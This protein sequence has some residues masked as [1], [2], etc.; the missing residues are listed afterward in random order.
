VPGFSTSGT[1][2]HLLWRWGIGGTPFPVDLS[3]RWDPG[4]APFNFLLGP[5]VQIETDKL[6]AAGTATDGV[7]LN[8]VEDGAL[9]RGRR[10][11]RARS[12]THCAS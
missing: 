7:T 2:R 12:F 6:S 10:P 11:Q 1:G 4:Y 5:S 9:V 3:V 8:A